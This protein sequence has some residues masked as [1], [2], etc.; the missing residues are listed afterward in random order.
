M[1][2]KQLIN[3]LEPSAEKKLKNENIDTTPK[4][5]EIWSS[6]STGRRKT[7]K[8]KN[9]CQNRHLRFQM[10]IAYADMLRSSELGGRKVV[11]LNLSPTRDIVQIRFWIRL[12]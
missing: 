7:I 8:K 10:C 6:N 1:T 9:Q 5:L 2:D 4:H 3:F 12:G 11:V